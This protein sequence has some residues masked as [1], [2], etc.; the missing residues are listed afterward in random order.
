MLRSDD[1][2]KKSADVGLSAELGGLHLFENPNLYG[3][4]ETRWLRFIPR[5][6]RRTE[7]CP[8]HAQ[9]LSQGF[10]APSDVTD[11]LVALEIALEERAVG[12]LQHEGV[13]AGK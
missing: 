10:V 3:E 7:T 2:L 5:A 6:E 8:K 4:L 11:D 12:L 9:R 13:H 1:R